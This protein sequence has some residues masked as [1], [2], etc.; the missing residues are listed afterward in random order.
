MA[1]L[2][3]IL[4]DTLAYGMVLFT[5]SIG[6]SITLGL[7][8]VVN[9]AHGGFAMLGGYFASHAMLALGLPYLAALPLAMACVVILA[10]PL[11]VALFRPLYGKNDY[12]VQVLITIGIAFCMIGLTNYFFGP[13]MRTIP[14]PGFLTGP[15][16][17]GFR[18]IP[19]HRLFVIAVGLA[20]A[21]GLWLLIEKTSFGTKLR[22]AVDNA[23]MAASLGIRT[24]RIYSLTFALSV[25][26]GAMG[27][28]IGAEL[29][30]IDPYY[31]LRY[32]VTI[33]VVVSIGGAGSIGGALTA[34]LL[35]GL[36][37]TVGKYLAPGY[38]DALFYVAVIGV[39]LAFPDGLL[40][41]RAAAH[42]SA[43]TPTPVDGPDRRVA[44]V[45]I[46]G[47]A[48]A[49]MAAYLIFPD[50]AG[51]LSRM[52]SMALLVLSLDLIVGYCG[53][54][55]LGQAALYGIGAYA[56]GIAALRAGIT[57]PV[58]MLGVGMVAGGLAGLVSGAL[59]VRAKGLAQL[60]LTVA[61][62]QLT[63][64]LG[65]KLSWLTGGSDGLSDI[66][67][68]PLF[69]IFA[70]D[71]EGVTGY[72]LGLGV[73]V[74]VL[75]TLTLIVHSPFGLLC[76]G[77][78]GDPVRVEAMGA[79]VNSTLVRMFGV[80]GM[81]AGLGGAL[82]AITTGVVG[83]DSLTFERSA[84]AFVML[85]LGGAGTLFGALGGVVVYLTTEH[86]IAAADPSHWLIAIG[87]VLIVVMFFL[88]SGLQ[89]LLTLRA[90]RRPRA[91]P[92]AIEVN[93]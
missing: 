59:I 75:S 69:G 86:A 7:M 18:F 47:I 42:A 65:N 23:G 17:L 49:G 62:L 34:A 77:I 40:G 36:I 58:A 27:G 9:L 30:P 46:A 33:L 57:D 90:R 3:S 51:Y 19:A 35:L 67:P 79:K 54:A 88:P 60:V 5:I 8:K 53:V 32:M 2:V 25:A 63:L 70:F 71:F 92:R 78:K 22:A 55:T 81:V 13:A 48:V 73:L 39:V 91:T 84:E 20:V 93:P 31:A 21:L 6:L 44:L 43:A 16:D 11:E 72:L 56:A 4:I 38:G 68:S 83:L 64:A 29:L 52:V 66:A 28:V 26:L 10:V 89:G 1:T 80:S 41:R 50:Y 24:Q 85:I 45:C 37:D 76:R 61:L 74:C 14:L 87:L 82:A 12:L 15:V